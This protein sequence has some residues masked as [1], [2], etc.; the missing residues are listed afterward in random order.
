VPVFLGRSWA[1]CTE[2][3]KQPSPQASETLQPLAATTKIA[4]VSLAA[5]FAPFQA[6]INTNGIDGSL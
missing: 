6:A 3:I 5:E 2:R 4:R 1:L